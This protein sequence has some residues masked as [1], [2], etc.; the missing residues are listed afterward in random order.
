M[1]NVWWATPKYVNSLNY[2]D[3]EGP[4]V[5]SELP[6]VSTVSECKVAT[7]YLALHTVLAIDCEWVYSKDP[8]APVRSSE[9]CMVQI[10]TPEKQVSSSASPSN[11]LEVFLFDIYVGGKILFTEGGLK[12]LLENEKITKVFHDCRWDSDILLYALRTDASDCF[13]RQADVTLNSVFDTQIGY[14]AFTFIQTG[15]YPFPVSLNK[16]SIR[17]L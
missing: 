7:D 4:K 6:I 13:S 5:L 3:K 12:A 9:L 16:V 11:R 17:T 10:A 2:A 14:A 1:D 8:S 15:S